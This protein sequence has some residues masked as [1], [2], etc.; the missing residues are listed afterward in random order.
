MVRVRKQVE[1]AQRSQLI[2]AGGQLAEITGERHRIARH[3]QQLCR[4]QLEQAL[5]HLFLGARPRR[6]D[7]EGCPRERRA[8][9]GRRT[10]Q[11]T[12]E[13][14]IDSL[15]DGRRVWQVTQVVGGVARRPRVALDG[16]DARV[17]TEPVANGRG[18]QPDSAVQIEVRRFF[19]EFALEQLLLNGG[20]EGRGRTVM[21][22]PEAEFVETELTIADTLDDRRAH[23]RPGGQG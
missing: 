23:R 7:D 11:Q 16:L 12:T 8:L 22:L 14:T 13:I 3:V 18:E 10:A 4:V 15:G 19:V 1:R 2:T 20:S 9:V 17:G 21:H 5:D 6:V